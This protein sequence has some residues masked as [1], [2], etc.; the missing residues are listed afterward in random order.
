MKTKDI[1]LYGI[2]IAAAMI[3]SYIE[4]FIPVFVA[5]PGMKIG[6]ANIVIVFALY[7][8]GTKQAIIISSL[9]I[10]LVALTFGNTFS[11]LYS[12]CGALLSLII[13]AVLKKTNF[14]GVT[15]V[16]VAGGVC[17]NLGQLILAAFLLETSRLMYYLPFLLI[18]GVITG[19]LI[20]LLAALITKR[21]KI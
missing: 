9:R 16:S 20:G 12:A 6:L 18:A 10:L 2:L 3:L 5:V 17:H 19:A 7:S 15:G 1:A 4:T 14:F 21:V 13:M 11:M 8:M